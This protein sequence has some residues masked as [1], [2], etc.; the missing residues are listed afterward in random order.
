MLYTK[1]HHNFATFSQTE[2]LLAALDVQ[3][4]IGMNLSLI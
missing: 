4:K 1:E 3:P 2:K